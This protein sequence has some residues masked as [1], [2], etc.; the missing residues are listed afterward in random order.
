MAS[1]QREHLRFWISFTNLGFENL[2]VRGARSAAFC[3]LV[4]IA[5]LPQQEIKSGGLGGFRRNV[6][7]AI[8]DIWG[9]EI[10]ERSIVI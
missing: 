6:D 5:L 2:A 3:C 7:L 4:A 9:L 8:L 10:F 1:G